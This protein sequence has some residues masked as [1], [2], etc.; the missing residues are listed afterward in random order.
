M[1]C[2]VPS[3][4]NRG[5]LGQGIVQDDLAGDVRSAWEGALEKGLETDEATAHVIRSVRP[6]RDSRIEPFR[7]IFDDD[8]DPMLW[9][10][11]DSKTF[12]AGLMDWV[13]P[14]PPTAETI[15]GAVLLEQG[16]AHVKTIRRNGQFVLGHRDL[17]LD[18]IVGLRNVSHRAGGIV[19]LY[20]GPRR[21]RPATRE[22]AAS[23]PVMGTW[24]YRV[25]TVLAERVFVEG[26]PIV[27][28]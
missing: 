4:Q 17:A 28:V 18:E 2:G 6:P 1:S 22:E 27:R 19:Y 11:R 21:L 24:G 8:A 5:Y 13:R 14:E 10:E 20:E 15:A 9:T 23:L 26:K 3:E 12:F 25:I 7:S 16:R